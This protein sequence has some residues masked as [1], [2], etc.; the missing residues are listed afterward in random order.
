V[1]SRSGAVQAIS[2]N[3]CSFMV[4]PGASGPCVGGTYASRDAPG[5]KISRCCS[6][7]LDRNGAEKSRAMLRAPGR[8]VVDHPQEDRPGVGAVAGDG[9]EL[10]EDLAVQ[11]DLLGLGE[12]ELGRVG[13]DRNQV[14]VEE[15]EA[16]PG[17]DRVAGVEAEAAEPDGAQR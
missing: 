14:V 16:V 9:G 3:V 15:P 13:L 1:P 10:I 8:Q 11:F 2:R 5:W 17:T 12:V 6:K 7:N 4:P